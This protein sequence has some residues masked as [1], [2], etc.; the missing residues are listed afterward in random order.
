L[1]SLDAIHVITGYC[2]VLYLIVH[3]YMSSLGKGIATY[4]KSMI[5]GYAEE[6]DDENK[7]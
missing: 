7:P 4:V 1:R 6:P 5:T 3:I 2:F